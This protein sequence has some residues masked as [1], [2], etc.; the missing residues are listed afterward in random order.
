[1]RLRLARYLQT[2]P[3][4]LPF[5]RSRKVLCGCWA[6]TAEPAQL[7]RATNSTKLSGFRF[8]VIASPPT[9]LIFWLSIGLF[10]LAVIPPAILLAILVTLVVRTP[11]IQ[12]VPAA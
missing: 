5:A 11:A 12:V 1:M 10:V 6:K 3:P 8:F 9:P 4:P 2:T 7:P